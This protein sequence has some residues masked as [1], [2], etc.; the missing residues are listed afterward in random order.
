LDTRI[1]V[2]RRR[3]RL[4]VQSVPQR[5]GVYQIGEIEAFGEPAVNVGKHRASFAAISSLDQ[6][7]RERETGRPFS[8][9]HAAQRAFRGAPHSA[10]NFRPARFSVPHFEQRILRTPLVE[11][12]LGVFEIGGIEAFGEPAVDFGE[13]RARVV[14]TALLRE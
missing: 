13:H 4:C 7:P 10:Q 6:H 12:R 1:S 9:P 14:A 5:L 11:Q 2:R 3:N 8:A